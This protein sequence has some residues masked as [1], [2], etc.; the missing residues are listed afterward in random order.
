MPPLVS[1]LFFIL[2]FVV[3]IRIGNAIESFDTWLSSQK[4]TKGTD[5]ERNKNNRFRP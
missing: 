5:F 4:E 1:W 3:G 2:M